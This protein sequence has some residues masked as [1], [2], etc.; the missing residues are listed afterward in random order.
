MSTQ[1]HITPKDFGATLENWGFPPVWTWWVDNQICLVF[2]QNP[3]E[4]I[5]FELEFF[6]EANTGITPTQ[7]E[8]LHAIIGKALECRKALIKQKQ[9]GVK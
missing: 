8:Q 4:T 1:H 7:L 6:A 9:R 5:P 2:Y 3:H